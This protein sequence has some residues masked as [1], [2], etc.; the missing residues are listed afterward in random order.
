MSSRAALF[1][2]VILSAACTPPDRGPEQS[3]LTRQFLRVTKEVPAFG[4]ITR[5]HGGWVVSLLDP[6]QREAAER[7]LR[8]IF[9]EESSSIAVRTRAPRGGA[10]EELKDAATDVLNVPGTGSLDFDETVGYLRVGLVDVEAV[11]PVQTRLDALDIPLE[12][13]ILQVEAPIVG[14]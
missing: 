9:K 8:D 4:G 14:M 11:E 2:C 3:P 6:G 12:Q 5:E 1:L 10:S 7:R 13:V